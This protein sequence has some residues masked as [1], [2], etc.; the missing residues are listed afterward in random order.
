MARLTIKDEQG[1]WALKGVKWN[2]LHVG[3]TIT[4]QVQEKIY[5]ALAKLKDYE[6]SGMTPDEC[7]DCCAG[8]RGRLIDENKL[9]QDVNNT[10]TEKSG[11]ID[12]INLINCQPTAYDPDK[13]VKQLEDRSSL[14]RPVGWSKT[15]EIITLENAIE[16]VKSGGVD[17]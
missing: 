9:M 12:W 14:A 4:Q 6:D 1:N 16:T 2:Q 3:E 15:Y 17:V 10:I 13:V 5:G 7:W 8:R 11:A